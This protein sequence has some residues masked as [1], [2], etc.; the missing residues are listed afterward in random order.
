MKAAVWYGEKDLRV[1]ERKL[2]DLKPEDVKVKVAWAGI[3]GSD[4]HAYLHPDAVPIDR[5]RTLGHEFSGIIE[6][7]GSEVKDLKPGDRVCIYPM[8]FNEPDNAMTERFITL[9]AVGAQMDGGFA[10]YAVMPKKAVFK[11]PD[12]LPLDLAAMVE[13]AAVSYQGVEDAGVKTGD[14]V[15]VYGVG[16]IGLFAIAAAKAK[17]AK[18]VI[19]VDI[20]A[21]RLKIA[22]E[23]GA[24]EIINSSEV[25]PVQLIH[26]MI[27]DG[28]DVTIEAAGVESAFKQ[29]AHS[30][31]IRGVMMIVSFYTNTLDISIPESILFTGIQV[32]GSV[33][34]TKETYD[35]VIDALASRQLAAEPMM[36]HRTTLEHITEDGIELLLNDPTQA[37]VLISISGIK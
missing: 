25:D 20:N 33:G 7:V 6:E 2:K 19:A 10:E 32:M 13:P 18:R 5:E 12:N 23:M 37:K 21:A 1:E 28:A 29:A 31:K 30:T 17:G 3:C 36:T 11:I 15:V 22:R 35:N 27:P 8:L 4:L 26:T 9:D 16:P 34:Y 24:D 14:D